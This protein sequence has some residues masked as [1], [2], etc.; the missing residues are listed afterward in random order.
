MPKNYYDPK[1]IRRMTRNANQSFLDQQRYIEKQKARRELE[2]KKLE[3]A[4]QEQVLIEASE[5]LKIVIQAVPAET[6]KFMDTLKTMTL[7]LNQV[8]SGTASA[9]LNT[10]R[11]MND[12]SVYQAIVDNA[13]NE[14]VEVDYENADLKGSVVRYRSSANIYIGVDRAAAETPAPKPPRVEPSPFSLIEVDD[15]N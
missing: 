2:E 4:Q 14:W 9:I 11:A 13:G 7:A 8:V 15:A 1:N 6:E 10:A 12:Q 5:N 3:A